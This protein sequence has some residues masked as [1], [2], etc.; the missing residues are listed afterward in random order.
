M[1]VGLA[2]PA[3]HLIVDEG[4]LDDVLVLNEQDPLASQ[5]SWRD[6]R[7][8]ITA[9]RAPVPTPDPG[10]RCHA[11]LYEVGTPRSGASTSTEAR[12]RAASSRRS[13]SGVPARMG[14]VP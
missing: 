2:D 11:G 10:D 3:V 13:W 7:R 6:R 12:P 5:T 4:A 1:P 9:S 14:K 8:R